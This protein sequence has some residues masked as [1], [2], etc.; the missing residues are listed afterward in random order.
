[1]VGDSKVVFTIYFPNQ[2]SFIIG[3]AVVLWDDGATVADTTVL[4]KN[5]VGLVDISEHCEVVTGE[6]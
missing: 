4:I 2:E 5:L 6:D 3:L 1:M